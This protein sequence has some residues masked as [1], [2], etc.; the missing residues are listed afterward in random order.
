MTTEVVL[1]RWETDRCVHETAVRAALGE[2]RQ[3]VRGYV[4]YEEWPASRMVRREVA[5]CE[6]ALITELSGHQHG[7]QVELSAAAAL[8]LFGASSPTASGHN[9]VCR[10]GFSKTTGWSAR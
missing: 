1:T 8:A 9:W 3:A 7:V 5:R 2:A 6:V 10:P 4:G